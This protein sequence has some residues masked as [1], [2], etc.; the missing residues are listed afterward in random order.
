MSAPPL[1]RVAYQGERG[2]FSEAAVLQHWG[3]GAVPVPTRSFHALL[4]QTLAGAVEFGLLPL[5]NSAIGEV[6]AA[7]AALAPARDRL[8]VLDEVSVPVRHCLLG[9]AGTTLEQVHTVG[10]HPAALAQCARFFGRRPGLRQLPAYDTAGAARELA[11]LGG[12][13][14][15]VRGQGPPPW[16]HQAPDATPESLG[17]LASATAAACHGLAVLAENVQDDPRNTTRFVVLRRRMA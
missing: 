3:A 4:E 14:A 16:F 7:Q 13:R 2:A 12:A 1:P 15:S 6:A 8:E 10:S 9:L 17:V 5:W 11:A